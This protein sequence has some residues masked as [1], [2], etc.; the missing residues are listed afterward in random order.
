MLAYYK[1][2]ESVSNTDEEQQASNPDAEIEIDPYTRLEFSF[3]GIKCRVLGSFQLDDGNVSFGTDV[4]NFLSPNHYKVYK[5]IGR[6]L[7]E[8]INQ[9]DPDIADDKSNFQIGCIRYSSANKLNPVKPN[10]DK[11]D[12]IPV[13]I[14]AKN[15]L[16]K[17]TA[18]FGM[19]RTGKS[20]TIKMIIQATAKISQQAP[21]EQHTSDVVQAPLN[22]HGIPNKPVGQII[23]DINGEYANENQ[24]DEGSAIYKLYEKDTVRY[25]WTKKDNFEE[26]RINFYR[27]IQEGFNWIKKELANESSDYV[28]NFLN[29]DLEKPDDEKYLKQYQRR[30]AAYKCCLYRAQFAKTEKLDKVRFQGNAEINALTECDPLDTV[31]LEQATKWFEAYWSED[32]AKGKITDENLKSLLVFLTRVRNPGS[33]F[34]C[35]GYQKLNTRQLHAYHTATDNKNTFDKQ[36]DEHLRE[37]KL[38]IIDLSQGDEETQ[39][40]FAEKICR[41]IFSTSMR[42]FIAGKLNPYIQFYFEEA[43]NLFPKQASSD[44]TDIYNRIAKEGAKLNLGLIYATQEV[45]SLSHNIL[46]NTANW[47]IAH[48]NNKDELRDLEKYYDFEDFTATLIRFSANDRGFVRMKTYSNPFVVPVQ[49]DKFTVQQAQTTDTSPLPETLLS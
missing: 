40:N 18:L 22:A 12:N 10:P 8:I 6:I 23:F 1:E 20:N 14:S 27:E 39:K 24:Q 45:S 34:R 26:M 3:S 35:S 4:D 33:E 17:R 16:G 25:S 38:V 21:D 9:P 43:H 15:F 37:G 28:E 48:L 47:F 41:T 46:T 49:V 19:T 29:I 13:Q 31:D 44:L 5:P 32:G 42:Q 7:E 36:I 30:L 2:S 11:P